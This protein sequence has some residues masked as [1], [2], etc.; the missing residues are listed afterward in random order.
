MGDVDQVLAFWLGDPARDAAELSRKMQRWFSGGR[1]LDAEIKTRFGHLVEQA[2]AGSLREWTSN[3]R[4]RLA[5]IIL[6]DQFTRNVYRS[7][8]RAYA[9]DRRAQEL[10][11]DAL[12]SGMVA[13]LPVEQRMFFLMPLQH[14]ENLALQDRSVA[15]VEAIM[16]DAPEGLRPALAANLEYARKYR[17]IIAEYGR[18]PHRN[19][20]LQRTPTADEIDF[21]R[22]WEREQQREQTDPQLEALSGVS[23]NNA[24]AAGHR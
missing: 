9:G 24:P 8:P 22:T 14:A 3:A 19:I 1:E 6:L 16:R 7:D 5:V 23:S 10:A 20:I 12:D 4:G 21:L 13:G 11:V 17:K 18:F 2:V 15:E